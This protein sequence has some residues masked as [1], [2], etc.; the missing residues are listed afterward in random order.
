MT[1][2]E[3]RKFKG[4]SHRTLK[5]LRGLKANNSKDWFQAHRADY[6]EYV[7]QPLRKLVTDLGDFMLD[8]DPYSSDD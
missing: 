8:I 4:F 3:G 2:K 6:E 5:F 1:E 7:L